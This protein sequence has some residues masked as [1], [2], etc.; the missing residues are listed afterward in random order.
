MGVVVRR[1]VFGSHRHCNPSPGCLR[2]VVTVVAD[3]RREDAHNSAYTGRKSTEALSA[4][5]LHPT[6]CWRALEPLS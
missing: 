5:P 2:G 1:G 3:P 6:R 4:E